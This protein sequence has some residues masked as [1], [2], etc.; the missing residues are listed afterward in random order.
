MHL[1]AKA[2][3][4]AAVTQPLP[5]LGLGLLLAQP[6]EHLRLLQSIEQA[7]SIERQRVCSEEAP[8]KQ[9]VHHPLRLRIEQGDPA[10]R[11]LLDLPQQRRVW[12]ILQ[13]NQHHI[14]SLSGELFQTTAVQRPSGGS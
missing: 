8:A 7:H 6:R 14:A 13:V 12:L 10:G 4:L 9:L 1:L 3:C 5:H 2:A 11:A